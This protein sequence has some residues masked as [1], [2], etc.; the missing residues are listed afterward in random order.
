MIYSSW[1]A[2]LVS[3]FLLLSPPLRCHDNTLMFVEGK[4]LGKKNMM[5]HPKAPPNQRTPPRH[6][7]AQRTNT[8]RPHPRPCKNHEQRDELRNGGQDRR[9]FPQRTRRLPTLRHP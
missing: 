8:Q 9:L 5:R 6:D 2:P 7:T 3:L 4:K 1:M